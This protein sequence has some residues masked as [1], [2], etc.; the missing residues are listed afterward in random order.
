MT[1]DVRAAFEQCG[2]PPGDGPC[3]PGRRLEGAQRADRST[4]HRPATDPRGTMEAYTANPGL[5]AHRLRHSRRWRVGS[6]A[7]MTASGGRS[8]GEA[9]RRRLKIHPQ[10]IGSPGPSVTVTPLPLPCSQHR[11]PVQPGSRR[12]PVVDQRRDAGGPP[13]VD[14]RP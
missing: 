14:Q 11:D 1:A 7:N 4:A 8:S 2:V 12:P 13:V 9:L 5:L 6:D 10:R 3:P